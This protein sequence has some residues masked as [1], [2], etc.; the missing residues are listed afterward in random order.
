MIPFCQGWIDMWSNNGLLMKEANVSTAGVR[1]ANIER[2]EKVPFQKSCKLVINWPSYSLSKPLCSPSCS[3]TSALGLTRSQWVKATIALADSA[4][5]WMWSW[6][7]GFWVDSRAKCCILN[8]SQG[9]YQ[10]SFSRVRVGTHW[11]NMFGSVGLCWTQ[12]AT[13]S[14]W[15]A[16]ERWDAHRVDDHDHEDRK[17]HPEGLLQEGSTRWTM[18]MNK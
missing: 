10:V 14:M 4:W 7:F 5:T 12:A 8:W 15:K 16:N 17:G 3:H 9:E 1:S 11:S 6:I 13:K 18:W 2:S